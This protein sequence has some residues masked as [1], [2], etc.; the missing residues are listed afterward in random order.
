MTVNG[1]ESGQDG[2]GAAECD[3]QFHS[4]TELI[5]ALSTGWYAG[6]SRCGKFIQVSANGRTVQAKIVDECDSTQGCDATHAG[7]PPRANNI[8]DVSDA[9]WT[10][11]GISKSDP[12]YGYTQVTWKDV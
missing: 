5:A 3:G 1:F 9:V 11:L 6:G 4:N 2:G 8:V 10:A 7:Q 12:L